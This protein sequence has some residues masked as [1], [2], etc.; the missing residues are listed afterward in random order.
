MEKT[1]REILLL[2]E[3]DMGQM[4]HEFENFE[5]EQKG[6]YEELKKEIKDLYTLKIEFA[7]VQ[8]IVFG[9][10]AIALLTIAGALLAL[11]MHSK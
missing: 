6:N 7:P 8:K 11:V 3:R 1:D 2:L 4:K 10:V 5:K 9:F